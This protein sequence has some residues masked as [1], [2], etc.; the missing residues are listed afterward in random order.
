MRIKDELAGRK[1]RCPDCRELLVVPR[2]RRQDEEADA[3]DVLL[4]DDDFERPPPTPVSPPAREERIIE[5]APR[6]APAP[7][8]TPEPPAPKRDRPRR[9]RRHS[10]EHEGWFGNVNAGLI[11]GLLMLVIAVVW[12]VLGWM[13]GFIFFYPP[14]LAVV[15]I[16]A[17]IK[18]LFS[19]D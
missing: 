15:G 10:G 12:F 16:G 19:R 1:V 5:R 13:A 3:A 11:G 4:A 7:Y 6:P 9:P 18:G 8:R 17:I 14:I 2:P